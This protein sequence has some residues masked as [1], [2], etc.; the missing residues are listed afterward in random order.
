MIASVIPR[1]RLTRNLET[2]EYRVPQH[3]ERDI[4]VGKIVNVSFRR[5]RVQAIV[6]GIT[7]QPSTR[8][9]L[10]ELDSTLNLPP[11]SSNYLAWMKWFWEHHAVS[12]GHALKTFLPAFPLKQTS[13]TPTE[14]K[15][16]SPLPAVPNLTLPEQSARQELFVCD[17]I[18][19]RLAM[20]AAFF[21]S[22]KTLLCIT[23]TVYDARLLWR[24]LPRDATNSAALVHAD[25]SNSELSQIASAW[26][27]GGLRI[28]I[29]TK[30]AVFFPTPPNTHIILDLPESRHQDN[31]EQNPRY[32]MLKLCQQRAHIEQSPLTLISHSASLEVL[33][34]RIPTK[35]V[36]LGSAPPAADWVP[37]LK[38][39]LYPI[40][41]PLFLAIEQHIA[42]GPIFLLFNKKRETLT[43]RCT[44]CQR[45]PSCDTCGNPLI[46]TKQHNKQLGFCSRC[47]N[48][49]PLPSH[50]S[51]CKS[52]HFTTRGT[53]LK[54]IREGLLKDF[55]EANIALLTKNTQEQIEGANIVLGTEFALPY[56]PWDKLSL[57]GVLVADQFFHGQN[58]SSRIK[59]YYQFKEMLATARGF[60][61]IAAVIQHYEVP[62][63][64]RA[65]LNN[66]H[67]EEAK[68]LN[69][70]LLDRKAFDYPPFGE[71]LRFLGPTKDIRA[72]E[73]RLSALGKTLGPT[74]LTNERSQLIL[75]TTAE[76]AEN[77]IKN[78]PPSIIL[79]RTSNAL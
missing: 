68:F 28:L 33:H 46:L 2:F 39:P 1:V 29:G 19:T 26:H 40:S 48:D 62:K 9:A 21:K 6:V 10:K 12:P 44:E 7:D 60:T 4:C 45:A 11:V 22:K 23:P 18:K 78:L 55:P 32:S 75:K 8:R 58:I 5:E 14:T 53:T 20:L 73:Q 69:T 59:G 25:M 35:R 42:Q 49:K 38:Q 64:I 63:G 16:S 24:L 43:T 74:Q 57:F 3:L 51:H 79:D 34:Q 56:L 77:A 65:A 31:A 71:I 50:C 54:K 70:E 67:E 37:M 47:A 30:R 61:Q 27:T 72:I 15:N 17:S 66:N 36:Q 41:H 52:S 76:L 13:F